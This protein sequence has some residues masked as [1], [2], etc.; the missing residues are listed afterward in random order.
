MGIYDQTKEF[1]RKYVLPIAEE[2]DEDKLAATPVFAELSRHGYFSLLI[3]ACYGGQGKGLAEHTSVCIALSESSPTIGLCYM[4]HNVALN[5]INVYGSKELQQKIYADIIEKNVF[6]SLAYSELNSATYFYQTEPA[7]DA[8]EHN[9]ILNG[10][11]HIIAAANGAAYYL[12]FTTKRDDNAVTSWVIPKNAQGL[13]CLD[14]CGDHA[15]RQNNISCSL[16][17][18]NLPIS[19]FYRVGKDEQDPLQMLT[20]VAPFFITGLA[21]VYTGLC[22]DA[23]ELTTVKHADAR[24]IS[25]MDTLQVHSADICTKAAPA[26]V[27][28]SQAFIEL[29]T[30]GAKMRATMLSMKMPALPKVPNFLPASPNN[31]CYHD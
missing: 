16:N 30:I 10:S 9:A 18:N 17:I 25:K 13:S 5:I 7:A 6:L 2:I 12:V 22:L 11:K 14:G 26:K 15:N 20:A 29:S 8:K 19:D 1:A 28:A 27:F 23:H 3:P 21:A 31:I 4:M 24:H